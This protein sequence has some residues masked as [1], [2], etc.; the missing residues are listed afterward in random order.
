VEKSRLQKNGEVVGQCS[1]SLLDVSCNDNCFA[2]F[3]LPVF[4][5]LC[6]C[7]S[8]LPVVLQVATFAN[9]D[10]CTLPGHLPMEEMAEKKDHTH[11]HTRTCIQAH[12]H[13]HTHTQPARQQQRQQPMSLMPY[14]QQL[15]VVETFPFLSV[16]AYTCCPP[17]R[18][19]KLAV[20]VATRSG[21]A[22][23]NGRC[24]HTCR[25]WTASHCRSMSWAWALPAA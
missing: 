22:P 7:V 19:P 15:W 23:T 4:F 9:G 13:V 17:T 8:S 20:V 10:Q 1:G 2:V 14:V 21:A 25:W 3:V 6:V 5:C 12:A 18:H 11:T 16:A 24:R